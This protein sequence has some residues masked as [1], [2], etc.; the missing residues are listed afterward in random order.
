MVGE[1]HAAES[2][3]KSIDYNDR[4]GGAKRV[5]DPAD[6][7]AFAAFST[8]SFER[9]RAGFIQEARD[10]AALNGRLEKGP[11]LET[12]LSFF[13]ANNGRSEKARHVQVLDEQGRPAVLD[14]PLGR[15]PLDEGGRAALLLRKGESVSGS[16]GPLFLT[17]EPLAL[18]EAFARG[19]RLVA[20]P[21]ASDDP[22]PRQAVWATG[23]IERAMGLGA[24]PGRWTCH[25]DAAAIHLHGVHARVHPITGKPF[26]ENGKTSVVVEMAKEMSAIENKM[27]WKTPPGRGHLIEHGYAADRA[28]GE[29]GDDRSFRAKAREAVAAR[30]GAIRQVTEQVTEKEGKEWED[31]REAFASIEVD[32]R[33]LSLL[34][35]KSGLVVTD[36]R[37]HAAL[38]KVTRE[39]S[40]REWKKQFGSW[41]EDAQERAARGEE[42]PRDVKVGARRQMAKA[43]CEALREIAE[44]GRPIAALIQQ[45]KEKGVEAERLRAGDGDGF[46]GVRLRKSGWP[47]RLGQVLAFSG[48][49]EAMRSWKAIRREAEAH[50]PPPLRGGSLSKS[51]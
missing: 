1:V 36:G 37:E 16:E 4:G 40:F 3:E 12:K 43:A 44:A 51:A 33:P 45:L 30:S 38:S 17:E 22:T 2:V 14:V 23:R 24:H 11:Y 21:R 19:A 9:S 8:G 25:L 7:V 29:E 5:R 27:G 50:L 42:R 13:V 41:K 20:G 39:F 6:R 31:L 32:G 34:R 46:E 48:A 18:E 47:A 49:E 15:P 26:G 35:K 28:S 10:A